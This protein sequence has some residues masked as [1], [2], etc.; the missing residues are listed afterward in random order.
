MISA[1]STT[2]VR[3]QGQAPTGKFRRV[4]NPIANQYIVVLDLI[5][6]ADLTQP[7]QITVRAAG[8]VGSTMAHMEATIEGLEASWRFFTGVPRRLVPDYVARHIIRLLWP[9]RLCGR[10]YRPPLGV[11]RG[12][13][14]PAT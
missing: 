1:I 5:P 14:N 2:K 9:T 8:E 12:R 13:V 4:K 10:G 6:G 7:G 11:Q 3:A